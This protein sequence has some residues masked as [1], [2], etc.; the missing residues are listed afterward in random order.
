[1]SFLVYFVEYKNTVP[2][3]ALF[4]DGPG[5]TIVGGRGRKRGKPLGTSNFNGVIPTLFRVD[6]IVV[7]NERTTADDYKVCALSN[8]HSSNIT[9]NCKCLNAFISVNITSLVKIFF[10][11]SSPATEQYLRVSGFKGPVPIYGVKRLIEILCTF[12]K[13]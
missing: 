13:N 12:W 10:L 3:E 7:R 2:D 4:V 5:V 6:N 9:N 8:E 11:L 1:M